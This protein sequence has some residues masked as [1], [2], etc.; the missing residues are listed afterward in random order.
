MTKK[1]QVLMRA[2]PT[3][4]NMI[5]AAAKLKGMSTVK[6]TKKLAEES[7]TITDLLLKETKKTKEQKNDFRFI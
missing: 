5:T 4:R 2:D 3:F 7:T 6:Y 1:K